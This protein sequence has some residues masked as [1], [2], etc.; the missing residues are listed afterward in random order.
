MFGRLESSSDLLNQQTWHFTHSFAFHQASNPQ[1]S[2][3]EA[4]PLNNVKAPINDL[5]EISGHN[6]GDGIELLKVKVL[7]IKKNWDQYGDGCSIDGFIMAFY[8][9]GIRAWG[10]ELA[11]FQRVKTTDPRATNPLATKQTVATM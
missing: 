6:F 1:G 2:Q 4:P 9:F 3:Q 10:Q 5:V 7:W 11:K 8:P